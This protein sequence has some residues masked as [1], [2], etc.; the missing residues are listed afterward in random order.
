MTISCKAT[1]IAERN[2]PLRNFGGDLPHNG[3]PASENVAHIHNVKISQ[4]I[5]DGMADGEL[6][7][8]R[9]RIEFNGWCVHG[10]VSVKWRLFIV[11]F[12]NCLTGNPPNVWHLTIGVSPAG[13]EAPRRLACWGAPTGRSRR[14]PASGTTKSTAPPSSWVSNQVGG[15]AQGVQY[16]PR[17]VDTDWT[18]LFKNIM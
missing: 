6:L 13:S 12:Q 16:Q 3:S 2:A 11:G 10:H 9:H 14:C 7:H 17:C 15:G 5:A 18:E 1:V 4:R 8:W